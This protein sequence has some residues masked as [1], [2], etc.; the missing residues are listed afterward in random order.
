MPALQ[1]LLKCSGTR[2]TRKGVVEYLKTFIRLRNRLAH[3]G[4]SGISITSDQVRMTLQFFQEYGAAL[5]QEVERQVTS[6]K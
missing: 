6:L 1:K 2:E 3:S 5:M 4:S